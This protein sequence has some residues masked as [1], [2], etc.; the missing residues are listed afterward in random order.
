MTKIQFKPIGIIHSP[1]KDLEGMPIQPV[2]ARGI[3]GE[4]KL[5]KKYKDGLKDSWRFF[6]H[7]TNLFFSSLKWLFTRSK[8]IS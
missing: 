3:K 7:Y 5:N 8:T 6:T 1:F 2:G 4:I